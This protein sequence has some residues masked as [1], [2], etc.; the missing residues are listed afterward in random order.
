MKF[1]LIC[2]IVWMYMWMNRKNTY[3]PQAHRLQY[4]N[5]VELLLFR[6]LVVMG[7]FFQVQN[8]RRGI[9]QPFAALAF[10]WISGLSIGALIGA[11][12]RWQTDS[13]LFLTCFIPGGSF[14][15]P[16]LCLLFPVALSYFLAERGCPNGIPVL[17]FFKGI[18]S[19][20]LP[21]LVC[22]SG[23]WI[24]RSFILFGSTAMAPVL[25]MWWLF[26]LEGNR[27]LRFRAFLL[28]CAAAGFISFLEYK[29]ISPFCLH[30]ILL[31]G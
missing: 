31:E 15:G 28:V 20:W 8:H 12:S 24:F 4:F 21:A 17:A 23:F 16:L 18:C 7:T 11:L 19:G 30:T 25:W 1:P 10:F 9:Q 13:R 6:R 29:V 2:S 26:L 3:A 5:C 14:F 27:Q 22:R